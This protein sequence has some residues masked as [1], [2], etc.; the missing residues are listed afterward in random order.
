MSW[1]TVRLGD[2]LVGVEYGTSR[3]VTATGSRPVVGM[4]D[5]TG[6]RVD[7]SDLAKIEDDPGLARLVLNEGDVLLNRTNSP[8]R[9]GKVG[10]VTSTT[11]AV[12]ASYLVRLLPDTR[13]IDSRYLAAHL[14][15]EST[16]KE[17]RNL[18]TRAVS[19]ANINPTV[20][21]KMLRIS[22]PP[23]PEQRKI[24]EILRAWDDAID[25]AQRLLAARKH[26]FAQVV[27][28]LAAIET[29]RRHRALREIVSPLTTRNIIGET[30]VLTTSARH[31]LVDQS[32]Y[33]SKRI[34]STDPRG[35]FLLERDDFAYNRSSSIGSPFG[36]IRRLTAH[37]R[38]VVSTLNLCFRVIDPAETAAA[39]LD[40]LF[41]S[42]YLDAQL[43]A[44]AHEG[45]RAHGL[46]NVSKA[47]FFELLI[48]LPPRAHQDRAT[49][50]LDTMRDEI[51]LLD[52]K[53]E[54][55]RTQKR[56]LAEKLLSGDLPVE[57]GE[58]DAPAPNGRPR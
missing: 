6:G 4:K 9:V 8:A 18:A 30:R 38:G 22:L 39:Y 58:P 3:P 53:L 42:G 12:F 27:R 21:R 1:P 40:Y 28:S 35:Y 48:P 57:T 52:H 33:F 23:V 26:R 34:A 7:T 20:L 16:Q 45:A 10:L 19:Q 36:A 56:G 15:A 55:L 47:E 46:L 11:D 24:A 41:Q 25:A 29:D 2:V 50:A 5:L 49:A 31:G 54:L 14:A 17:I 32:T 44:I 43:V 13:K 51:A 37:D